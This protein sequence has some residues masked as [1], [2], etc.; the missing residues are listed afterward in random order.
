MPISREEVRHIALL[1]RVGLTDEEVDCFRDQLSNILE[2]FEILKKVDTTDVPATGHAMEMTNILR[3]D[4][5]TPSLPASEALANAP[6]RDGDFVRVK[7]VLE[8]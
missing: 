7:A 3:P 8:F 5:V 6:K 2:N 1:S 4:D